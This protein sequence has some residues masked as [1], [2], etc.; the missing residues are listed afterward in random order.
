MRYLCLYRPAGVR[1]EGAPPDP[2]HMVAMGRLIEEMT[3]KGCFIG[4]EPLGPRDGGAVVSLTN[5][6]FSVC[7]VDDRMGGY[8]FIRADNRDDAVQLC[9]D[10]LKVAGDGSSE[11][12]P[13]LEFDAPA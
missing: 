9:K 8:A 4:T 6:Q 13:I 2:E 1:E 7:D 12:R 5:G 3:A 11:I 10:F